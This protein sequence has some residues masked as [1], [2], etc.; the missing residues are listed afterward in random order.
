MQV[1]V[2]LVVVL[3]GQLG[4]WALL[5]ARFF[6][7]ALVANALFWCV[8]FPA[9][10][11]AA[12]R[13]WRTAATVDVAL[14]LTLILVIAAS[15]YMADGLPD[16]AYCSGVFVPRN[17]TCWLSTASQD[18]FF[19]VGLFSLPPS[20]IAAALATMRARALRASTEVGGDVA[21]TNT[22]P[23]P[24]TAAV[25]AAVIL[26]AALVVFASLIVVNAGP[27]H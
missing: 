17:D 13:W 20:L 7:G 2:A 27:A 10:T 14:C 24:V 23:N 3:A 18:A 11:I 6:L 16:A 22:G 21:G 8:A 19:W 26:G 4:F 15:F 5:H 25:I 1:V 9:W 12:R